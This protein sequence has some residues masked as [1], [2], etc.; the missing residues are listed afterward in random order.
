MVQSSFEQAR[1]LKFTLGSHKFLFEFE[2]KK[3]KSG[4]RDKER[5]VK[6]RLDST[7]LIADV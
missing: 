7:S 5:E 1:N 4:K 6:T 2:E 3:K